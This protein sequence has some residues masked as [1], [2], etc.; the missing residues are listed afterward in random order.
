MFATDFGILQYLSNMTEYKKST[1]EQMGSGLPFCKKLNLKIVEYFENN[2]FQCKIVK[3]VNISS[4]TVHNIKQ[5]PEFEEMCLH[6]RQGQKS[7]F[8]AYDFQ[9]HRKIEIFNCFSQT[10]NTTSSRRKRRWTIWLL[11]RAQLKS[12]HLR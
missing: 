12:L 7:I 2:L 1:S 3:T 6:K 9:A 5:F 4:P 11:I 8:D 10:N